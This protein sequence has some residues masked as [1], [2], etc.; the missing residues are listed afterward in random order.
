MLIALFALLLLAQSDPVSRK[1]NEPVEP[2]RIL[3]NLYY[4]G[5]ADVTSYLI[6][7]P[8]GLIVLDGGFVETAPQIEANIRKLGFDPHDVRILL[9]SHAHYD[10]AGGLKQL[11]DDTGARLFAS[12]GDAPLLARGGKDD[13]QFGDLFLFPP[14]RP[15]VLVR[16]RD[17]VTLGGTILVAHLTPGHTPGC[18]TWTTRIRSAGKWYDVVF[19]GSPTVPSQYRLVGNPK[20]PHAVDDYRRTFATLKSLP[21]DVFLGAHGSFFHLKEKMQRG[22]FIDPEGYK[23][24]LAAAEALFDKV[25]K[26]QTAEWTKTSSH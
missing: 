17:R 10:H 24:F 14:V 23:A 12:E 22:D 16:D 18:T 2:F 11:R 1:A 20:Y 21:C 9:N 5:A 6:A 8:D 26:K 19:V 25:L 3:G 15:D 13:P 7:T 4:V